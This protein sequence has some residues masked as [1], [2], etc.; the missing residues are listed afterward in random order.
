MMDDHISG[1][2]HGGDPVRQFCGVRYGCR[3]AHQ[4]HLVRCVDDD[5]LP[6]RAAVRVLEEVDLIEH[7]IPQIIEGA[8]V[9]VDHVAQHLRCHH[10]NGGGIVDAGVAGE[11]THAATAV[12]CTQ[13]QVLLVG[14]R[15]DWG[16][17]KRPFAGRQRLGHGVL[18]HHCFARPRGCGHHHGV[19]GIERVHC[20]HL[21]RI[22]LKRE[23][24]LED[25][26]HPGGRMWIIHGGPHRR[27]TFQRVCRCR[28]RRN[29]RSTW[30]WPWQTMSTDLG[31]GWPRRR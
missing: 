29:R 9:G 1:A 19:T 15:L 2:A 12:Q 20:F 11:Q 14:Q 22:E 10:H 6:Y 8:G 3:Q 21:E 16:G 28:W 30:E 24:S 18:R 7:H 4:V 27:A 13:V 31:W 26:S 17:V 5:L 25:R 23:T